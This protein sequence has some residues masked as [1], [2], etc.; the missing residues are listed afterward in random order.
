MAATYGIQM[1]SKTIE[2][3][4]LESANKTPAQ[5]ARLALQFGLADAAR[6]AALEQMRQARDGTGDPASLAP[7]MMGTLGP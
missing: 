6:D 1:S 4:S 2:D 7:S 5:R 3:G